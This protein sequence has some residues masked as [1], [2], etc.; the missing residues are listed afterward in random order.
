MDPPKLCHSF[1]VLRSSLL[2]VRQNF[3]RVSISH[4]PPNGI[5]L[6]TTT[7]FSRSASHATQGRA[8]GPKDSAGRRLGAKKSASEYVV[9]G[10]IIFR[11]RGRVTY[12]GPL[13]FFLISLTI[14]ITRHQM[15][16][17]RERFNWQRP[18]YL[19]G[20]ERICPLLSRP[21]TASKTPLYW[22]ITGSGRTGVNITYTSQC[23]ASATPQYD[24][25]SQAA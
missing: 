9:P 3:Y 15:V 21:S 1:M 22:R 5:G 17:R 23:G 16:S 8:N 4:R 20:R 14:F 18:H 12:K 10:N 11:Q 7:T 13:P 19:C 25:Y 24:C 6:P 2:F